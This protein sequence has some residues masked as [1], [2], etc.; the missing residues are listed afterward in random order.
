M[1][2][3]LVFFMSS[4]S[5]FRWTALRQRIFDVLK[6]QGKP[7]GAYDVLAQLNQPSAG[8]R[9]L[10]PISVYRV[11]EALQEA[12][13]VHRLASQNAYMACCHEH[14]HGHGVVFMVCEACGDTH[15]HVAPKLEKALDDCL[16]H[17]HFRP[18]HRVVEV[19][20]TC[21]KC[22]AL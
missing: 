4:S 11:L 7:M 17:A 2:R 19:S 13:Y 18:H 16:K 20:G 9:A 8:E 22:Q 1:A 3:S 10:A 14:P 12:G 5:S 21:S 6:A 15:E